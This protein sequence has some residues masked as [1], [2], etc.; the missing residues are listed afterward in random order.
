MSTCEALE[1]HIQAASRGGTAEVAE[2]L[3]YLR[4]TGLRRPD[5]VVRFGSTFIRS[6]ASLGDDLWTVLE[7]VFFAALD[8]GDVELM[9]FA[10][11]GLHAKF[12]D[13]VRVKRLQGVY[14]ETLGR[15]EEAEALYQE[16]LKANPANML[17]RRRLPALRLQAGDVDGAV[18]EARALLKELPS[19]APTWQFLAS[20]LQRQGDV[21]G[22]R[23]CREEVLLA[24]PHDPSAH[25]GLGECLL[26]VGGP[27]A[28]RQARRHFAQ[29]CELRPGDVR[30]ATGL[31]MASHA[32]SQM[33]GAAAHSDAPLNRRLHALGA[34]LTTE[35]IAARRGSA[36]G[37]TARGAGSEAVAAALREVLEEQGRD[38]GAV[39]AEAVAAVKGAGK[40]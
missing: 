19:D 6:Q 20:L 38:V 16:L 2:L 40:A 9:E 26:A 15:T 24:T 22:A 13:S 33:K 39:Q 14:M 21:S 23:F 3:S 37:G 31:C 28:T 5:L 34:K 4:Q 12:P 17:I 10:F 29:A 35:A 32:L 25:V 1:A 30:A 18:R 11:E 7:Q 8:L 36:G 27:D